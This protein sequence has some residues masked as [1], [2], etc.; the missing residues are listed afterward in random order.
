MASVARDEQTCIYYDS[1]HAAG[2]C[3]GTIRSWHSLVNAF[4]C[5][6]ARSLHGKYMSCLAQLSRPKLILRSQVPGSISN[7]TAD[8]SAIVEALSFLELHARSPV[9]CVLVF[10]VFAWAQSM[11]ARMDSS[12][13][14]VNSYC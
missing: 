14:L 11:L 9:M 4:G 6:V 10:S 2:L 7:N 3:L 13:S 1:L 8:M 5:D 12:D